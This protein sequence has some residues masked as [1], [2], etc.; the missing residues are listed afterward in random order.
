MYCSFRT[1]RTFNH[2]RVGQ[3]YLNITRFNRI[4]WYTCMTT[5]KPRF[6]HVEHM[7][8][9]SPLCWPGSITL[10]T[11]TYYETILLLIQKIPNSST[12]KTP[13]L[14][15]HENM[16]P[17]CQFGFALK[18]KKKNDSHL[19]MKQNARSRS[20]NHDRVFRSVNKIYAPCKN[21]T[22]PTTKS[23]SHS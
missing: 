4:A 6:R 2:K 11:C 14:W 21:N 23:P 10:C 7:I 5:P 9:E 13:I 1:K 3:S 16:K 17:N 18:V 19:I 12:S 8:T 20:D 22:T 15:H